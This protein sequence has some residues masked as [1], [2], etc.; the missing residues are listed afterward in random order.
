MRYA[1]VGGLYSGTGYFEY[2]F[3]VPDNIDIFDVQDVEFLAE[4]S[5]RAVQSQYTRG[6]YKGDDNKE[7]DE[8][9]ENWGRG[10]PSRSGIPL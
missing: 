10:G 8:D 3:K 5:A 9:S 6:R 7:D 1:K 2:E 4:L